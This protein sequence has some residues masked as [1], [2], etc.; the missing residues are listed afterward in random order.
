LQ[1]GDRRDKNDENRNV[2]K[3]D[4]NAWSPPVVEKKSLEELEEERLEAEITAK[5]M[6]EKERRRM[7][8]VEYQRKLEMEETNRQWILAQKQKAKERY[9]KKKQLLKE[10]TID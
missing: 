2:L 7:I 5:E 6:E 1:G 3:N 8:C 9:Q 10:K 4:K